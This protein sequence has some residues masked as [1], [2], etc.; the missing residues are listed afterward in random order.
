MLKKPTPEKG[1]CLPRLHYSNTPFFFL[2]TTGAF[3]GTASATRLAATQHAINHSGSAADTGFDF[4][5]I[6]DTIPF[7]GPTFHAQVF[8]CH[9]DFF[10]IHGKYPMRTDL[11]TL[12]AAGTFLSKKLKRD[13]I[14]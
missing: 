14:R 7:T 6:E 9:I 1:G 12:A 10:A 8:I 11:D 5:G 4:D 13:D 2:P 3:R